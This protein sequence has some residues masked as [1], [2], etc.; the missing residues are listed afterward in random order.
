M[1]RFAITVKTIMVMT[2]LASLIYLPTVAWA[3]ETEDD[4]AENAGQYSIIISNVSF[5]APSPERD[6]LNGEWVEIYNPGD[7][8]QDF[9]GWRL[10]DLQN[11]VY[12][13]P[14][15]FKL[16]GGCYVKVHSGSGT[17]TKSDLYINSKI[18][19]WNNNGDVAT[20]EDGEGS[21]V[22]VFP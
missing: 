1:D 7:L 9:S 6:N 21:I 14:D 16:G 3:G 4:E 20:L 17:D 8:A 2:V 18:S 11:H 5:V 15:G 12:E 22:Y 19:I 13:F 10:I